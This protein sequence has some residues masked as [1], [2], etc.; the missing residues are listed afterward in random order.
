MAPAIW[1]RSSQQWYCHPATL[2]GESEW[3]A[4]DIT[5]P[6]IILH[7][8]TGSSEDL[9]FKGNKAL[10]ARRPKEAHDH[11]TKILYS[12]CP[13]HICAFMNRCLAYLLMGYPELAVTDAY[14]ATQMCHELRNS[15]NGQDLAG[16]TDV[17]F[18][19]PVDPATDKILGA[20]RNYLKWEK[21]ARRNGEDWTHLPV[22]GEGWQANKL[23]SYVC[24]EAI[25]NP[26]YRSDLQEL[27]ISSYFRLVGSLLQCSA[28]KDGLGLAED[29]I[30]KRSINKTLLLSPSE[31]QAFKYLGDFLIKKHC[32]Q[33]D[34]DPQKV[35]EW[36][37]LMNLRVCMV[38]RVVYPW[39]T[40]APRFTRDEG[41]EAWLD[42]IYH[43]TTGVH[44]LP[45]LA[46]PEI[47][48]LVSANDL[49]PGATIA[50]EEGV[51]RVTTMEPDQAQEFPSTR[52]CDCCTRTFVLASPSLP[53]HRFVQSSPPSTDLSIMSLSSRSG[54]SAEKPEHTTIISEEMDET[55]SKGTTLH[56][57]K[58]ED[59]STPP[60]ASPFPQYREPNL[61]NTVATN[62]GKRYACGDC[63]AEYCSIGCFVSRHEYHTSICKGKVA[64]SLRA[65][66]RMTLR[67]AENEEERRL[68]SILN[69]HLRMLVR[70]MSQSIELNEHPL[71][72]ASIK[73]L[74]GGLKAAVDPSSPAAP[75]TGGPLRSE[76]QSAPLASPLTRSDAGVF[77]RRSVPK[78]FACTQPVEEAKEVAWTFDTNVIMPITILNAM[79]IKTYENLERYDGWVINTLYAKIRKSIQACQ[80]TVSVEGEHEIRDAEDWT[81]VIYP[82]CSLIAS[83]KG[84]KRANSTV[85]MRGGEM[86]VNAIAAQ[87]G[88]DEKR[89]EGGDEKDAVMGNTTDDMLAQEQESVFII[90]SGEAII[91]PG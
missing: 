41:F 36:K 34:C 32:A 73:Y 44:K 61:G 53:S 6:R 91:R 90:R 85:T 60:G 5:M 78:T 25:E 72:M 89:Q 4:L 3:P 70:I 23:A 37:S 43:R 42:R 87:S 9:M 63:D 69:L 50:I 31:E 79:G 27:E 13:G 48:E 58:S 15:E 55:K 81:G 46:T 7:N 8:S 39:D 16:D 20:V 56:K 29:I 1:S 82:V 38:N 54:S 28:I 52:V 26:K 30:S 68:I 51:L 17:D 14:R 65:H 88:T 71:S 2:H 80:G 21:M 83:T 24:S 86:V 74:N 12:V 76:F 84:G 75:T 57:S 22:I 77:A 59:S 19:W 35:V 40:Q 11:Y 10:A 64:G 47:R 49:V 45:T 62:E 66:Y 33:L 18:N 67:R